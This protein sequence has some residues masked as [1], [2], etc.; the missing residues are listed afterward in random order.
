MFIVV[1]QG[2]LNEGKEEQYPGAW[3]ACASLFVNHC[4]AKCA[5]LYK[6]VL[7]NYVAISFWPDKETRDT[8]WH[9]AEAS[10]P[11]IKAAVTTIKDCLKSYTESHFKLEVE[12]TELLSSL[13]LLDEVDNPRD[14]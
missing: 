10:T 12:L 4:G 9:K 14:Q 13:T 5:R 7:G 3:K 8:V 1:Y 6:D 2:I 11:E